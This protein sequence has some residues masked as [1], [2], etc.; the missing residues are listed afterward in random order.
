[1]YILLVSPGLYLHF[2]S[3]FSLPLA[4]LIHPL[5]T[6]SLLITRWWSFW[7]NGEC[8]S[9]PSHLAISPVSPFR[10][11]S[12]PNVNSP[13]TSS[14]TSIDL[15]VSMCFL[16]WSNASFTD[17]CIYSHST[18]SG[19]SVCCVFLLFSFHKAFA[20]TYSAFVQWNILKTNGLHLM[21]IPT[22]CFE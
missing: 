10:A 13:S 1:M 15:Q 18:L 6:S 5:E 19:L 12:L 4:S 21:W 11:G 9:T 8:P 7:Q 20:P 3:Y 17:L 16:G 22:E 2:L 14:T